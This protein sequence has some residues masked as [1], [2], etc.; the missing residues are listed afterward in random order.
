MKRVHFLA[1]GLVQ[2]VFY[3]ASA[4]AEARR[5][6]LAGWVRNLADGRVEAVAEGPEEALLA[7]LAWAR[8]GPPA[9]R[10]EA[11]EAT[12]AEATGEFA[13]FGVRR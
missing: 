13:G 2:G 8:Q 5:L 3:R 10:V 12:W 11:V 7:L 6:G 9:A 4:E 1:S